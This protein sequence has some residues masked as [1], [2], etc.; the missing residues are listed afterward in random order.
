MKNLITPM[1]LVGALVFAGSALAHGST[2]VRVSGVQAAADTTAGA[3]G[4]PC[5]A[6]DPL[7]GAAPVVSNAMSGS[8]VGCWY[9]DTFNTVLSTPTGVIVATGSEHFVG[10]LNRDQVGTCARSDRRGSL[11]FRY[12][13]EGQFDSSG[14]EIWGQCQHQITSGSGSFERANGWIDFTDNVAN[15]TASYLGQITLAGGNE[16]WRARLAS[17]ATAAAPAG[18]HLAVC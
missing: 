1:A 7:T 12:A 18:H 9:T 13:F 3:P 2:P 6:A 15:A 16:P 11:T 14:N 5:A 4:D 17:V 8:L 10:C